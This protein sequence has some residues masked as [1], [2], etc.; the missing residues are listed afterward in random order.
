MPYAANL[1][2]LA[3]ADRGGR[4]RRQVRSPSALEDAGDDMPINILM[5]ALSPT[6]EEGQAR[7]VAE[8]KEGDTVAPATSSPRSRPTR[9]PWRSRRSTR[10]RSARSG[11][12]RHRRCEGQHPDRP[13]RPRARSA[14]VITAAATEA[15]PPGRP[16]GAGQ[17][18]GEAA[19]TR[20]QAP[21]PAVA[22][23]PPRRNSDASDGRIFASPLARRI[24]EER[25][26]TCRADR[27]GAARA[28]RQGVDVETAGPPSRAAPR[29]PCAG[30]AAAMADDAS[31]KAVRAGNLSRSSRMTACARSSPSACS[32]PSRRSRIST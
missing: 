6:M 4:C 12:G 9:R 31:S 17:A 29:R 2:K 24:A 20:R 3:L 30:L 10:A 23:A 1:E 19:E 22:T 7:Q 16:A 5:P 27:V 25:A 14:S 28:H 8:V 18:R 32:R 11:P 21:A 26:S 15:A 13:D